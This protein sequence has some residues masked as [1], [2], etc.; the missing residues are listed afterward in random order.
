MGYDFLPDGAVGVF[1]FRLRRRSWEDRRRI[2]VEAVG[3]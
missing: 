2:S 3:V 1:F